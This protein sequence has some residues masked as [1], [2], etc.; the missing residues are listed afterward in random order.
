MLVP[1][2]LLTPAKGWWASVLGVKGLQHHFF[3]WR[4][5]GTLVGRKVWTDFLKQDLI[6]IFTCKAVV[7]GHL[8]ISGK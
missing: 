8:G 4:G 5:Y 3:N 1:A 2:S 6:Q 7:S